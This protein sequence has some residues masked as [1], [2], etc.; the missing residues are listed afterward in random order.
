MHFDY[1]N[2][3]LIIIRKRQTSEEAKRLQNIQ[4]E[5]H[6][7]DLLLSNDVGILRNQ[8]EDASLEFVEAQK[9]YNK[10]EK[11]F[12]EAKHTLFTKL[13][14]KELLTR[15]LCT[16]IEQSEMRKAQKLSELMEKLKIN[17]TVVEEKP[18]L[19]AV[20]SRFSF[21]K[22]RNLFNLL[23]H[24]FIIMKILYN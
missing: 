23:C 20:V 11:E 12:L 19:N 7:L 17:E 9:R 3:F 5:L 2:Y 22:A 14:K 24:S 8:I 6:K 15:H 18:G 10:A 16:I 13:E 1:P 21:S 4:E